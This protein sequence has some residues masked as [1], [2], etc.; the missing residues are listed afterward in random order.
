MSLVP[1][2]PFQPCGHPG[3]S[4]SEDTY[5]T[6]TAVDAVMAGGGAKGV[7]SQTRKL[8]EVCRLRDLPIL[9]FCNKMDR[10][11]RETFEIIDEIKKILRLIHLPVGQSGW[12][13]NFWA[14]TIC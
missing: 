8:F 3:H 11:S 2:F 1:R 10:E 9:T 7:K 6:L 13:V 14:I 4:V 5:R 12:A